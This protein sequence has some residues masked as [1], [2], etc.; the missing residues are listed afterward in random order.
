MA[1]AADDIMSNRDD[2]QLPIDNNWVENQNLPIAL[3]RSNWLFA[4]P[5]RMGQRAAA[6]ISLVQSG[7]YLRSSISF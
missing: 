4:G 3:G 5:L 1:Q 6:V 2:G 7:R